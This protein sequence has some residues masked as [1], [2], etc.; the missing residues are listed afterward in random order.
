MRLR[1][2]KLIMLVTALVSCI[3]CAAFRSDMEGA[4]RGDTSVNAGAEPVTVAFVFTHIHQ[5]KGFDAVPKLVNSY[6]GFDDF[7]RDALPEIMNIGRYETFTERADDVNDPGRRDELDRM[8][9]AHDF[10][11]KTTFLRETSFARQ[12][13]GTI[14]STLSVTL[15]PVPYT[16]SYAV[17][18]DVYDHS[19]SLV[20][21]YT[22]SAEVTQWVETFLLFAYPFHPERRKTEEVYVAF[23]HDIFR[24]IEAD[25]I[26]TVSP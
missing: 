25:G 20:K 4:Y 23:L 22:R 26:L 11:I 14:V 13:F 17:T 5:T 15:F 9:S 7:F 1:I 6:R 8:A 19:G 21:R 10:V 18:A 3:G 12:T 16:R 2:L 24:E